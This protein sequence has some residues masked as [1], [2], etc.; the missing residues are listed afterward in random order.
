MS[1]RPSPVPVP[2][3]EPSIVRP[4][5]TGT[6]LGLLDTALGDAI[7]V[8]LAILGLGSGGLLGCGF[9]GEEPSV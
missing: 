4:F 7:L 9:S 8:S 5:G 3:L 6:G 2:E 1:S